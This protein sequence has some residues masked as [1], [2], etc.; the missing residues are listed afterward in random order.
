MDG[1]NTK[2]ERPNEDAPS[3]VLVAYREGLA[4]G[5]AGAPVK[6]HAPGSLSQIAYNNG[7]REGAAIARAARTVAL[8]WGVEKRP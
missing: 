1:M 6:R 4:D 7:Y 2:P 3:P 5:E 8:A